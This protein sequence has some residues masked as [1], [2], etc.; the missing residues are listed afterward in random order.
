MKS[1]QFL[2]S[3]RNKQSIGKGSFEVCWVLISLSMMNKFCYSFLHSIQNYIRIQKEIRNISMTGWKTFLLSWLLCTS[4]NALQNHSDLIDLKDHY[5]STRFAIKIKEVLV[6]WS[7][8]NTHNR[9]INY[10]LT[11]H[12]FSIVRLIVKSN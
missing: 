7:I 8:P 12:S 2:T 1:N 6:L 9:S 5:H 10:W 11:F 4:T 3:T